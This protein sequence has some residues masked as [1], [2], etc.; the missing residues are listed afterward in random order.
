MKLNKKQREILSKKYSGKCAYCGCDLPERW[1]A[2]P[3]IDP[4]RNSKWNFELEKWEP[5]GIYKNLDLNS[6]DNL[7]PSCKGC[8]VHKGNKTLEEFRNSLY[9][10]LRLVVEDYGYYKI[11]NRF[12]ML[13]ETKQKVIFYFERFERKELVKRNGHSHYWTE[14]GILYES[15]ETIRGLRYEKVCDVPEIPDTEECS[16]EMIKYI[17][18]EYL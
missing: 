8:D 3:I 7:N 17:E 1:H 18:R 5:V 12:G 2:D 9:D 14:D 16:E 4:I 10:L 6:M 13:Q 15:Y 11:L